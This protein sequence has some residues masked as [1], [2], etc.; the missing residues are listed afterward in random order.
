LQRPKEHVADWRGSLGVEIS[1]VFL[2]ATEFAD[3][4]LI[5]EALL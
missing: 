4:P 3:A 1:K 5:Q 2:V